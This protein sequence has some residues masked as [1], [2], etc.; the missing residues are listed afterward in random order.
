M[1]EWAIGWI[2]NSELVALGWTLLHF[3]WEGTAVA[4]AYWLADRVTLRATSGVR[5]A[6]ALCAFVLMPLT[7]T[8]TFTFEMQAV[9]P[10]PTARHSAVAYRTPLHNPIVQQI[11]EALVSRIGER[12]AGLA[13]STE[14]LLPWVDAVW[15]LGVLIL[16]LRA[17][18]GWLQLERI[19]RSARHMVSAQLEK[20][21]QR[22]R[23]RLG[24][25]PQVV[26]RISDQVISPL[27]MGI[28]RATVILPMSAVLCLS[29]EEL[30]A[31][32]AHELGHIRRLDYLCNLLQIAVESVLFFH[33]AVWWVSRSVRDRREV[34][35]DEIAV[36]SC[37]DAVVYAQALLRLEEQKTELRFAMAFAG[38][39]GSLLGRVEKVL[40]EDSAMESGM[41]SGV[42]VMVAGA[43]VIGL[44]LGPRVSD[45]V[46]ASR[47]MVNRV[48][49]MLPAEASMAVQ[50]KTSKIGAG[51]TSER[52][53]SVADSKATGGS[54]PVP[55]T[56][57][58]ASL[59][60]NEQTSSISMIAQAEAKASPK[61][62]SYL[63]GMRDAGYPLD[64]DND[65]NTL[66]SLKSLGVT[67]E[68]AKAMGTVGLGKP[69]VHE[70]ISLKS[71]GITPEY[72]SGLKQSGI[73]PKDFHEV[74][75]EKALGITPEY[76]S[77]MKKS[78]FGD[79][80]VH[81]LISMKAQNVTPEYATW[82][83]QQF[84]QATMNDLRRA[85]VFHLDEKFVA[86]AKSH[87][88]DGNDLDKLLRL[89]I[90][91][92]LDE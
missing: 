54:Q 71:L 20:S 5:Y 78:G 35:C 58:I 49:A 31:V 17:M 90:S 37:V 38:R 67:P 82:L 13:T 64:L 32:L 72:V 12:G 75:T 7:V 18:G 36:R 6:V 44:L 59:R 25:G 39:K 76:A 69:T 65:L 92:L 73:G 53:T 88:M 3:C 47:P 4:V 19:R 48:V 74:V 57:E 33:P 52:H 62:T 2:S 60:L 91:G 28:W 34:C 1:N 89:K 63:D 11:P 10:M 68:Y 45:A 87:G 14:H 51:Q 15:M 8:A 41:T 66:V 21:F 23:K 77:A 61:G 50:K 9:A 27:A 55:T 83:K 24:I 56:P 22:M 86:A 30:E 70:L 81:E 79:L 46:A 85:A 29:S 80:D 16:S 42:R 84:P 43:V 26:L 40:G